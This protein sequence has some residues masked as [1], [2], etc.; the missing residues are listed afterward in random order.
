MDYIKLYVKA[1]KNWHIYQLY[2]YII[3]KSDNQVKFL[4][5]LTKIQDIQ[6]NVNFK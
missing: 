3:Y 1:H 6:L 5:D 2:R 4:S